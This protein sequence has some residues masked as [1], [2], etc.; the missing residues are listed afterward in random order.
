MSSMQAALGLAQLER[1]NELIERKRLIFDWYRQELAGIPGLAMN[2]EAPETK[3]TYWMVSA[4]LDE[5]YKP[6]KENR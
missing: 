6:T 3:N 5:R 1:V 4:V 2:Y